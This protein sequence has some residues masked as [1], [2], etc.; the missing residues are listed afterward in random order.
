[1]VHLI[2]CRWLGRYTDFKNV[3]DAAQ[4]GVSIKEEDIPCSVI[5]AVNPGKLAAQVLLGATTL[6]LVIIGYPPIHPPA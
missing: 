1:M 4:A 6:P 3:Y 5:V 2:V